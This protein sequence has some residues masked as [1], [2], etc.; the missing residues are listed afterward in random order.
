MTRKELAI[1]YDKNYFLREKPN[2]KENIAW[3]ATQT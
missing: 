3:R 1:E 2:H